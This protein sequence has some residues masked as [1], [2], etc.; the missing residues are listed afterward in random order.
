MTQSL[1]VHSNEI[2]ISGAETIANPRLAEAYRSS[3]LRLF[4]HR[5][6]AIA[7][8][9]GFE[10]LRDAGREV[11]RHTI[12]NL[13]Y[14]LAQF[15]DNVERNGG[16]V[17]WA[18]TDAEVC[19]IV[20]DIVQRSAARDVVK[21]KTMV[22]EE[23]ELNHA[24]EAAGI[25]PIETDLGE[26]IIQLS[27]ERPAHI[28]A[29]AIH[30][31]R[32]DVSELFVKHIQAERTVVPEELTA[33]ARRALREMFQKAGVGVSGANFA[34]AETG[35]VVTIENEGN[36][37]MC[38]T[39]PRV[40]I[41][42]VGIEKLV[43]R[44]A[45]LGI[46][47]RLLGRSGTGQ[48]LTTYTSLLTGPCREGEDGP[49]EMHVVMVDNGRT[50][51]LADPKMREMLYCI[52]C[53]A[54]LNTCPVYRKIGGHAYGWVYSGPI[55]ALVTPELAGIGQA[56]ELPFASSL[57]GACREVCPVK[58]NIPDLL[59]HLRSEAQERA[60]KHSD[61]L[62]SERLM[63]RLWA[64]GMRHPSLYALCSR[65]ARWGQVLLARGGWIRKIPAYPASQ[66]TKERDFPALAARS[67]HSRWKKL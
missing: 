61:S 1:G 25:R 51:S 17:H 42:L 54:C 50:K 36:I 40:H 37:R 53:G 22:G 33:I 49:Q 15:S 60:P 38:S 47:L 56:R 66:W 9:P 20:V 32:Q 12:E 46:F 65:L 23:V 58:I 29:P 7:E 28:V 24:L 35:T 57:C 8:V 34:V 31:T 18:S 6:Q 30:L 52:R 16:K 2:H 59:L 64:W 43:P 19:R 39:V 48:K 10:R 45:D 63:F 62:L 27:G 67:F 44:I 11:K 5:L 55:G 14:Y 41:A 13:D 21:A 4:N 3:T 26:F